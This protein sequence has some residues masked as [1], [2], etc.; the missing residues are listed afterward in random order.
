MLKTKH[1]KQCSSPIASLLTPTLSLWSPSSPRQITERPWGP[2]IPCDLCRL[3]PPQRKIARSY[4]PGHVGACI[5]RAALAKAH[6]HPRIFPLERLPWGLSP[7]V[8]SCPEPRWCPSSER[9][10]ALPMPAVQPAQGLHITL[11]YLLLISPPTWASL[12][13]PY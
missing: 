1:K 7:G 3:G 13:C 4:C 11:C 9:L 12:Y 8:P 10:D 6:F 2:Y 5:L